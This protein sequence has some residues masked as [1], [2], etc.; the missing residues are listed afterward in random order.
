[1]LG[2][3]SQAPVGVALMALAFVV[4]LVAL[5]VKLRCCAVSVGP[6]GLRFG[7]AMAGFL[8]LTHGAME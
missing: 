7:V 5:A 2:V 6:G 8:V 4:V 1:M 3:P